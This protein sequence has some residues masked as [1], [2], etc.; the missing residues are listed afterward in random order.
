MNKYSFLDDDL[1]KFS[2][3]NVCVQLYPNVRVKYKFVNRGK[4]VWPDGMANKLKER[5]V[6]LSKEAIPTPDEIEYLGNIRYFNPFFIWYL[7]N[8]RFDPSEV[9]ISQNIDELEIE[10]FWR[11]TILWEC[12]IL[13]MIS[14]LYYEMMGIT[15]PER[16]VLTKI[17][18]AKGWEFHQND[19]NFA[20]FG[21]RRRFS[22]D[23]HDYVINDLLKSA[24]K[25]MVGTSN[26]YFAK[27]YGIKPIGTM[28]HE[29]P[30]M[31]SA[32]YG[33]S[34]ANKMTLDSW[35][36][37]YQGDLGIALP[38]TWTTDVFLKDFNTYYAKLFDGLRQDSGLPIDIGNKILKHYKDLNL[39]DFIIKSKTIVFSDN[40]NSIKKILDIENEFR[41]KIRTS[42]GIGTWLTN[43]IPN[44]NPLNMVIKLSAVEV[45]GKWIDTIKLSDDKGKNTGNPE[46]VELA[47]RVFH[48]K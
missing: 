48:I 40:I 36:K 17:N 11:T 22:F 19:I 14:E 46:T 39:D 2:Q 31:M 28:A 26:V 20:D 12:R 15:L 42:Y 23:N 10:G 44:V 7:S 24:G 47:K 27:K 6:K 18:M 45:D 25:N 3:Q 5:I 33:F 16:N 37:I 13:S 21:T 35:I 1:Y 9:K 29:L 43:N 30:M 34:Q 4:T 41:G 32:L 38:D 8:Y